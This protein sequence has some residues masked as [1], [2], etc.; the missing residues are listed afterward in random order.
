MNVNIR[1]LVINSSA[2]MLAIQR[3]IATLK[4]SI[5]RRKIQ[6]AGHASVP[7]GR[8]NAATRCASRKSEVRRW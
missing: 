3:L 5:S 1:Q 2:M 6:P 7:A 4:T 8:N